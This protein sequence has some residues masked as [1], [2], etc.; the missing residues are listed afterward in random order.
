MLFLWAIAILIGLGVVLVDLVLKLARVSVKVTPSQ[1][2]FYSQVKDLMAADLLPTL[3]RNA[4][5]EG[6]MAA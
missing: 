4:D 3:V 1:P 2:D 6:L 5:G